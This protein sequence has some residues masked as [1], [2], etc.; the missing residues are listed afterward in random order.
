M[1]VG[2]L[3]TCVE[4]QESFFNEVVAI[5]NP[6]QANMKILNAVIL[7][8]K[9]DDKIMEFCKLIKRL[10]V[11]NKFTKELLQFELGMYSKWNT[12]VIHVY[13]QNVDDPA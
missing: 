4:V 12:T 13:V 8:L 6:S 10:A 5:T 11:G 1:T 9:G 7:W 3:D 2:I